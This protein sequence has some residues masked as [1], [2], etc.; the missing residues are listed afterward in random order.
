M[1]D[2]GRAAFRKFGFVQSSIVTRWPEIVGKAHA[3][4][5]APESIRFPAGRRAGGTLNLTVASGHGP[6]IQHLVPQIIERVNRFFGYA[7]I[8]RVA[9][10]QGM[11]ARA[12]SPSQ[13][14]AAQHAPLPDDIGEG[15]RQV[16]DPEL[17]AVLESL[18]RGLS[19]TSGLPRIG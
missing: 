1:P 12:S 5:T 6:I 16:A 8:S 2:I 4:L 7:A 10:R 9:I 18:A 19:N 3:E 11:I 15:L 14:A 17:R 13:P